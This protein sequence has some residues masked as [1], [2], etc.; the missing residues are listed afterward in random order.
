MIDDYVEKRETTGR[1]A[2][3]KYLGKWFNFKFTTDKY[4][5][6]DF[7]AEKK[8]DDNQLYV[9]EIKAFLSGYERNSTK[10]PDYRIDFIKLYYIKKR[11]IDKSYETNKNV[12][13]LLIVFFSDKGYVWDLNKVEW[14]KTWKWKDGDKGHNRYGQ[15]G[16]KENDLQAFLNFNEASYIIEYE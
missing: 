8:K 1:D 13:P 16:N 9:G 2:A 6:V 14:E 10:Y 15:E 3:V 7:L 5:R 12:T 11:A 4:N